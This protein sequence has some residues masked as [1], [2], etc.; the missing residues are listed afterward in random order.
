MSDCVAATAL[1]ADLSGK[2]EAIEQ[3]H[4]PRFHLAAVF[5]E[6]SYAIR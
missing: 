2:G 6:T 5:Q 4:R 1:T 3:G